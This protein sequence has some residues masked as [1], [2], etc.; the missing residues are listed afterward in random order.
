MRKILFLLLCVTSGVVASLAVA[1][2]PVDA[3]YKYPITDP[4]VATVVGTPEPLRATFPAKVPWKLGKLKPVREVPDVFWYYKD[5]VYLQAFQK[6][7]APLIFVIAGTGA[8]FHSANNIALMKAFYQAGFH[9]AGIT[10]PT[11]QNFVVSASTTA[12][13]GDLRRDAEDLYRIMEGIREKLPKKVKVSE[14]YL[15]GYSLGGIQAAF[16]SKLD[17]DRQVF[18]FSK[19]LLIN[20]PVSLYSSIGKLDRMLENVPG[21]M[22]NFNRFYKQLVHLVSDAYK[23][24]DSV[25]FNE[26]LIYKA[27]KENPP[28]DEELAAVIGFAFRL[29]SSSMIFSADVMTNYGF[30][31][32]ANVRLT[33]TTSLTTYAEVGMRVG[34]TDY[35]HE[36]FYPYYKAID[37]SLT[38]DAMV[39]DNS[40]YSIEDYLRSTPKIGIVTNRD[41]IILEQGEIDFFPEVFGDRAMIY[42]HGG[43]LG[44][45]QQFQT[46]AYFE[47]FFKQ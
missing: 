17:E 8:A 3:D 12:V 25:K 47:K 29:S 16:V 9:V 23:K 43:H 24:S 18:N 40:L 31:K 6:H 32:P 11:H 34:F 39:A 33:K 7:E 21:G 46:M 2:V 41:D 13:P 30:I 26:Q 37:P 27:F 35:F 42:P 45:L 1:D 10:S 4:F 28:S 44:N 19:V 15:T 38:R 22:T 20:P 36:F 5:F 14:Y